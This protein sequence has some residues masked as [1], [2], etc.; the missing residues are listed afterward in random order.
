[1]GRSEEG[2]LWVWGYSWTGTSYHGTG[3]T[4][5]LPSLNICFKGALVVMGLLIRSLIEDS[6]VGELVGRLKEEFNAGGGE[7]FTRAIDLAQVT[8]SCCGIV[9]PE[10]FNASL[11]RQEQRLEDGGL[12]LPLSCCILNEPPSYLSPVPKDLGKCQNDSSPELAPARHLEVQQDMK[13]QIQR[14]CLFRV[15][16]PLYFF[17]PAHRILRLLLW[18]LEEGYSNLQYGSDYLDRR[19]N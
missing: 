3:N 4:I 7:A 5:H 18:L 8:W 6:L 9:G 19:S 13:S 16:A 17:G 15:A 1:M 11:W 14:K 2:V 12:V 10:D